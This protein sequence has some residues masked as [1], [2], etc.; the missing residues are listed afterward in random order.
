[1]PGEA[2]RDLPSADRPNII[3]AASI[4]AMYAAPCGRSHADGAAGHL[5]GF[6]PASVHLASREQYKAIA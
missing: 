3:S 2:G 1:M 4:K 6:A 5:A